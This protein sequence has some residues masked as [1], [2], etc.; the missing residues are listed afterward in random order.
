MFSYSSDSNENCGRNSTDISSCICSCVKKKIQNA[1]IFFCNFW[2]KG[3]YR[4]Y[5]PIIKL[6]CIKFGCN[7]M[8]L[9]EEQSFCSIV[10]LEILQSALDDPK[11]NSTNR[12]WKVPSNCSTPNPKFSSVSSTVIRVRYIPYIRFSHWLLC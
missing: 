9:E 10:K 4:L 12:T 5:C 6:P 3:K 1:I 7:R 2:Q 11:Q 8:K